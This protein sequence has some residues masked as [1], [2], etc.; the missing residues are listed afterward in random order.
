MRCPSGQKVP[1]AWFTDY[2]IITDYITIQTEYP[3]VSHNM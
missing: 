3:G 2:P 1:L